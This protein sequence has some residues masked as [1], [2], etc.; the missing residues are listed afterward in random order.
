M[1]T[2]KRSS[3][4]RT[5]KKASKELTANMQEAA[6]LNTLYTMRQN[7]INRQID[8]RKDIDYECGYPTHPTS[9]QYRMMYDREGIA[10]RV[11]SVYPKESW[12]MD[13]MIYETEDESETTF[14]KAWDEFNKR[15]NA[16][17]YLE[18]IDEL[19]GIGH[20]GVL[21]LGIDDK[22]PDLSQPVDGLPADDQPLEDATPLAEGRYK[23]NFI[24]PIDESLVN[25]ASYET[26]PTHPRYGYPKTYNITLSDPHNM[27]TDGAGIQP[28]QEQTAVH[29]H[30]IIHIADN[31]KSSEV[32]GVPR[33][34]PVFNRL[35]DLRKLLGGSA[36]MFWKGAFPG[37]SFEVDPEVQ[38]AT[39]LPI[40]TEALREEFENY[41]SGLQRYMAATGVTAK[42]LSPQVADPGGHVDVQLQAIAI[43]LGVPLRVFMGSEQAKLAS[44]QDTRNW[45][46]RLRRRQEKYITPMIIRRFVDRMIVLGILPQ[47]SEYFVEWPDLDAPSEEDK[48]NVAKVMT[49]AMSKYV[50]GGVD[51]LIPPKEY[52][53]FMLGMT[54]EEADA[55]EEASLG[56][57]A[58]IL[59]EQDGEDINE[60][61]DEEGG[62]TDDGDDAQGRA[63]QPKASG[64]STDK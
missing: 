35:Y 8:S 54:K 17:H 56:Y 25:V 64:K 38:K 13:P 55:I 61:D 45:N 21:L 37:Y 12:A 20:Y 47:P 42:S 24:R 44:T 43:T 58:E 30:R 53:M 39:G 49:E 19:S 62:A 34:R 50:T 40:D 22:Q 23:L 15:H 57:Q 31:C 18:R 33:M 3:T 29:W 51:Q 36:E 2:T 41:S 27:E 6:V 48:A 63:K 32:F 10:E 9:E 59:D 5:S 52:M 7:L 26:D 1:A 16:I 60:D 14:E 11:V 28:G 46:K 4:K